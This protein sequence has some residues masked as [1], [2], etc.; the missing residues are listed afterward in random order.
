MGAVRASASDRIEAALQRATAAAAGWADSCG[1]LAVCT[2]E[3]PLEGSGRW[4][5]ERRVLSPVLD[6]EVLDEEGFIAQ[7]ALRAQ[8]LDRGFQRKVIEVRGNAEKAR[9]ENLR[10]VEIFYAF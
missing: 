9:Q 5:G 10:K 6:G 4:L 7:L 8:L 1:R 3:E 2:C